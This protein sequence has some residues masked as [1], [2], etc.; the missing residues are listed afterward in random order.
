MSPRDSGTQLV[1]LTVGS[2]AGVWEQL[3]FDIQDGAITLGSTLI[4]PVGSGGGLI[5][6]TVAG[7]RSAALDGLPTTVADTAPEPAPGGAHLNGALAIDHV[8]ARTPALERTVAALERAGLELRRVRD[9][10]GGVRQGFMWVG[11]TILELVEAPGGAADDP[12]SFWGL[13]VVV[14]D[15]DRAVRIA[16]GAVGE[17]R[18][19]VQP[20]RRIATVGRDAGVGLPLAFMTP[21]VKVAAG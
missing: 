18:D 9:A 4:R 17:P 13:V 6:W 1:E 5:G 15:L 19:A 2:A 16:D 7:L 20:G 11:D 3:G 8:V 12:A 14:A 10:G 21:H